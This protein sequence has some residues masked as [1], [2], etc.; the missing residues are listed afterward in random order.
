MT[1]TPGDRT[2]VSISLRGL[3]AA[4]KH[5]A[6]AREPWAAEALMGFG[7]HWGDD[8]L[9]IRKTQVASPGK[10]VGSRSFEQNNTLEVRVCR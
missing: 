1:P 10:G 7:G 3:A 5:A 8:G 9:H 2:C 6:R 4:D